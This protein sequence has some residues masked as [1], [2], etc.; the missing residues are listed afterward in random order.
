VNITQV[1]KL[2]VIIWIRILATDGCVAREYMFV[3]NLWTKLKAVLSIVSS[4]FT[5]CRK[6]VSFPS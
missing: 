2:L 1:I 3:C 4:L 6:L 5:T